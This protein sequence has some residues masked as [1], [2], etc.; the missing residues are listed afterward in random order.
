MARR[1]AL[2]ARCQKT[3]EDRARAGAQARARSRDIAAAEWQGAIQALAQ[4]EH[5][6][7]AVLRAAWDEIS[8]TLVAPDALNALRRREARRQEE[9]QKL[10]LHSAERA[11]ALDAAETAMTAAGLQLAAASRLCRK[12]EALAE[13]AAQALCRALAVVEESILED[14][15]P[16]IGGAAP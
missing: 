9:L 1:T 15:V 4:Y 13:R 11:S 7:A 14:D 8:A 12:R 10:T 6:S 16:D 5:Q 2:L 3:R